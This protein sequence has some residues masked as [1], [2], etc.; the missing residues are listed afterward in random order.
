REPSALGMTTGSPASRTATTELVVPRSMPTALGMGIASVGVCVVECSSLELDSMIKVESGIHNFVLCDDSG[1]DHGR[2]APPAEASPGG[3]AC[4]RRRPLK[5][6]ATTRRGA[7]PAL[8]A[9]PTPASRAPRGAGR[10]PTG[11][12]DSERG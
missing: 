11:C 7:R 2:D 8:R 4:A 1:D 12:A 10:G 3:W 5:R 6:A 9:D